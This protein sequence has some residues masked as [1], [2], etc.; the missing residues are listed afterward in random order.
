MISI[1]RMRNIITTGIITSIVIINAPR[2]FEDKGH[3]SEVRRNGNQLL[4]LLRLF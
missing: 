4:L 1:T 3:D 2:R